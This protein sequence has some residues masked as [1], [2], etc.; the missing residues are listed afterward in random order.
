MP[1]TE[2]INENHYHSW[3]PFWDLN[4]EISKNWATEHTLQEN[5][6]KE[7]VSEDTKSNRIFLKLERKQNYIYYQSA[8]LDNR[9]KI[10]TLTCFDYRY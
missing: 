10:I 7:T 9:Y 5:E 8:A 2:L 1:K 4:L 6:V 3:H